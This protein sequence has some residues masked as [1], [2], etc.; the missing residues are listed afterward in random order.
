MFC[1][2][3]GQELVN[4]GDYFSCPYCNKWMELRGGELH[5]I[6]PDW[7]TPSPYEHTQEEI[8]HAQ[9]IYA[10]MKPGMD[11]ETCGD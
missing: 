8:D 3:C 11:I 5:D 10:K 4:N 1:N 7:G 6:F 9:D 2:H